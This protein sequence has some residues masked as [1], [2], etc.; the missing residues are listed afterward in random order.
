MKQYRNYRN[1][2]FACRTQNL[3]QGCGH[4][5]PIGENGGSVGGT[6][7]QGILMK[8]DVG[9]PIEVSWIARVFRWHTPAEGKDRAG[10]VKAG[11]HRYEVRLKPDATDTKSG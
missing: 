3:R 2:L 9:E 7:R 1:P 4:G 8:S 5:I 6:K 10:P 11:R